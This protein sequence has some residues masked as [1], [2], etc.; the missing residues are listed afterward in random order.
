MLGRS[1]HGL[2]E[3]D[4]NG[5]SHLAAE[6]VNVVDPQAEHLP[7]SQPKPGRDY[8]YRT[9]RLGMCGDDGVHALD[10]PGDDPVLFQLGRGHRP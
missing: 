6:E 3:L 10:G 5:H 1:E 7:L 9:V 4:L 2:A 8:R